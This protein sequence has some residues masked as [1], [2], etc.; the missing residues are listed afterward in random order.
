[1]NLPAHSPLTTAEMELDI[2]A[3]ARLAASRLPEGLPAA[4]AARSALRRPMN[5]MRCAELPAAAAWLALTPGM[6][7]LDVSSPQWLTLA[8]AARHPDVQFTYIN[9][10]DRELDPFREIAFACELRNLNYLKADVRALDMP[11]A[12]FD[13]VLS[14]SVIE[15]VYPEQGGD[16][17]ALAE[18]KRVLKPHGHMIITVPFKRQASV[19]YASGEVYERGAAERN[20][21]AREYDAANFGALLQRAGLRAEDRC[22][23]C[24]RPGVGA[25]DHWQWG[26]GKGTTGARLLLLAKGALERATRK[27]LEPW[28]ARRHLVVTPEVTHRPVNVVARL[29]PT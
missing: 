10:I 4:E 22:Y 8:L 21:Y 24:E 23:V 26:P 12:H 14:V 20:F 19:V 1:M 9:I 3:L 6:S 13:A 27:S 18:M 5:Y 16:A 2:R 28:L 11:K 29:A 15:H 25:M 17:Q 7:V